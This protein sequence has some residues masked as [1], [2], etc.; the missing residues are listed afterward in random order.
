MVIKNGHEKWLRVFK[1][2]VYKMVKWQKNLQKN[3]LKIFCCQQN[4]HLI[5]N[6]GH[7]WV[8]NQQFGLSLFLIFTIACY[9]QY[10]LGLRFKD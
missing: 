2:Y 7:S 1:G 4:F 9:A 3:N 5:H 8:N 6:Q 10:N